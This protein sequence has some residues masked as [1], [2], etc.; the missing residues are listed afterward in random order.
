VVWFDVDV[1]ETPVV[2]IRVLG[3]MEVLVDGDPLHL[4]SRRQ[5]ALLA[6]LVVGDGRPVTVTDLV[7]A[8]WDEDP[9]DQARTTLQTYVS[10]V[11]RLVGQESILHSPAGYRLG[12]DVATDLDEVRQM[13]AD[14]TTLDRSD[15]RCTDLAEEALARW[16]GPALAEFADTDWFRAAV[17]DM[18]EMHAN[19]I[20]IA[21]E[22]MIAS[23]R[24][25]Q[26]VALLEQGLA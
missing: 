19:L 20:D 26:A 12:A 13:V 22:G 6:A 15:Q 25:P 8:V 5:R 1:S 10:R 24:C 14:L 21:A 7:D 4:P 23:R 11:R 16:T 9:P 2:S 3:P 17:V 18:N